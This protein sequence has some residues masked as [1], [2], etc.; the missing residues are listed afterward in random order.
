MSKWTPSIT[1]TYYWANGSQVQQNKGAPSI[2]TD[3]SGNGRVVQRPSQSAAPALVT[4]DLN[5]H[6][7]LEFDGNDDGL[8]SDDASEFNFESSNFAV[9]TVSQRTGGNSSVQTIVDMGGVNTDGFSIYHVFVS[10]VIDNFVLSVG[11]NNMHTESNAGT[12]VYCSAIVDNGSS[13]FARLDGA[14]VGN[15]AVPDT[16]YTASEPFTIGLTSAGSGYLDGKVAEVIVIEG[17]LTDRNVE[18]FEGY[19]FHKYALTKFPDSH[20]FK[21]FHPA[22]GIVGNH[23]NDTQGEISL[24]ISGSIA[25]DGPAGVI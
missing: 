15:P 24:D 2:W 12:D 1:D 3:Q 21:R 23:N 6:D 10:G 9:F 16:S 5:G 7:V 4:A 14:T 20:R 11:T 8:Q 13:A 19:L 18:Q 17:T 25:S 22:F